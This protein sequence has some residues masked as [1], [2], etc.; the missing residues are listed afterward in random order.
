MFGD[1][2]LHALKFR[3]YLST[4]PDKLRDRLIPGRKK[5]RFRGLQNGVAVI[6]ATVAS[7]V[8]PAAIEVATGQLIRRWAAFAWPTLVD[9][10]AGHVYRHEGQVT[11]GGLYANW[12]RLQIAQ[13][14]PQPP[15]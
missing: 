1:L 8:Q 7:E 5:G 14:F 13:I 10:S 6:P 4:L 2:R 12:M 15:L 3:D 9:T 11:I